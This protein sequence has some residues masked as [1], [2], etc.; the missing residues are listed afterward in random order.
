MINQFQKELKHAMKSRNK[1]TVIGMRNIIGKLKS[2]EIDKGCILTKDE[3]MKI[4][5]SSVKQLKESIIQYKKGGREDLAKKELF[6]LSLLE[7]Y[8]PEQLSE[9][10]IRKIVKKH[11]HSI[12]AKDNHDFG[13]VMSS[14]MK[15][16]SGTVDGKLVQ[17]IVREEL[18]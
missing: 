16:I 13:K 6:E 14:L 11:I 2:A 12:G 1:E 8:L 4:L 9:N 18:C 15:E 5:F 10:D 7:K 17:N 3:S